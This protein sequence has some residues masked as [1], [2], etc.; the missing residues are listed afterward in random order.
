MGIFDPEESGGKLPISVKENN[1]HQNNKG[2]R[3]ELECN[4]AM[5]ES[6]RVPSLCKMGGHSSKN[7]NYL[8]NPMKRVAT[9]CC[10]IEKPILALSKSHG[11]I[12]KVSK[13]SHNRNKNIFLSQTITF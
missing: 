13:T 3:T 2:I 6:M 4:H 7:L 5:Q 12:A 10:S 8:L 9:C 11:Y 1:K